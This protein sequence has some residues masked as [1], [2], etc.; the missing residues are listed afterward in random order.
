MR[1]PEDQATETRYQDE[2]DMLLD[3]KP[4]PGIK[5]TVLDTTY[6]IKPEEPFIPNPPSK[7]SE[8]LAEMIYELYNTAPQYDYYWLIGELDDFERKSKGLKT[9]HEL[10]EE[11]NEK[12]GIETV[13][14]KATE[15]EM[16][17][18]SKHLLDMKPVN[19]WNYTL[20]HIWKRRVMYPI[21]RMINAIKA[22]I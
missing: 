2:E 20:P 21:A 14:R 1:N 16:E 6:K 7:E 5:M 9:N 11:Y 19:F 22:K 10:R 4:L 12:Y 18:F 15:E 17:L 8:T 3:D 13:A